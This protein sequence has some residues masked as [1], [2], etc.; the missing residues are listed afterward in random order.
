MRDQFKREQVIFECNKGA[1]YSFS[2]VERLI[3][4]VDSEIGKSNPFDN[5]MF[6]KRRLDVAVACACLCINP[7]FTGGWAFNSQLL[8]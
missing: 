1:D 2:T 8:A 6:L 7:Y 4:A 3:K 5:C